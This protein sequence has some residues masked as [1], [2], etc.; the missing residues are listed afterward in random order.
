MVR[1]GPADAGSCV[2]KLLSHRLRGFAEREQSRAAFER[3]GDHAVPYIEVDTRVSL[4]GTIFVHHDPSYVAPDGRRRRVAD[5]RA[6]EIAGAPGS[7]AGLVTL[8]EALEY[9][10]R[11]ATGG[12][13]LCIDIK[14]IGYE[15]AHLDAVRAHGLEARTIFVSWAP[16]ALLRLA[17]IGARS[18]L[19]LSCWHVRRL[20]AV[21]RLIAGALRGAVM[22]LGHVVV[23][24]TDRVVAPLPGLEQ[25]YQHGLIAASLPDPLSGLLSRSMGGIC[26]HRTMLCR[27]LVDACRTQGLQLWVFSARTP[28]E[29]RRLACFPGVAVVFSEDAPKILAAFGAADKLRT[30]P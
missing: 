24:G 5:T 11:L 27:A 22:R 21:G 6:S 25:G 9:F 26:V 19:V 2:A 7:V 16:Q 3:M 8:T 28:S 10:A 17:D 23:L 1:I 15:Q 13:K 12:Q 20:G 29:F 18:P 14:D 30:T 4:D